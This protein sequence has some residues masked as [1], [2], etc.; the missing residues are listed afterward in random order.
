MVYIYLFMTYEFVVTSIVSLTTDGC[1]GG[2]AS[3]LRLIPLLSAQLSSI[4][5]AINSTETPVKEKHARRILSKKKRK[6]ICF[7]VLFM[8]LTLH[9]AYKLNYMQGISKLLE[10]F[11]DILSL[12]PPQCRHS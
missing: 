8:M 6:K 10:S 9:V 2:L 4:S 5:K 1:V 7:S 3:H 12:L 11:T